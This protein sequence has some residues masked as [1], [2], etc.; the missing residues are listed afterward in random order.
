MPLTGPA[1]PWRP[2]ETSGMMDFHRIANQL[3]TIE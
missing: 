1:P 3:P 2:F